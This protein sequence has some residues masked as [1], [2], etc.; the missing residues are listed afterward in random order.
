[1]T[2][3]TKRYVL[4]TPANFSLECQLFGYRALCGPTCT[5]LLILG[6]DKLKGLSSSTHCP[7]QHATDIP[8]DD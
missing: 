7:W 5:N 4:T 8:T 1:M 2:D 3:Y 6:V